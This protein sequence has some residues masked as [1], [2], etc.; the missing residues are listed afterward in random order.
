MNAI[1][2]ALARTQKRLERQERKTLALP[3]DVPEIKEVPVL[4]V[5]K[6]KSDDGVISITITLPTGEFSYKFVKPNIRANMN[7]GRM[8]RE[9]FRK[10]FLNGLAPLVGAVTER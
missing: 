2:Q 4:L 1:E 10:A 7:A 3:K 8:T 6:E 5:P 9:E